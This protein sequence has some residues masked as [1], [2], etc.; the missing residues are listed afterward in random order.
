VQAHS[1]TSA[2]IAV[3]MATLHPGDTVLGMALA[4][5]GH[6]THGHP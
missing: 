2:N 5:G 3:Y 1:G 4:H 6:L